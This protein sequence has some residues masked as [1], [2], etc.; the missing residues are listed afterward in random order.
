[1]L[2]RVEAADDGRAHSSGAGQREGVFGAVTYGPAQS[3]GSATLGGGSHGRT[4]DGKTLQ[5]R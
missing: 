4:V 1:M 2:P 5:R 3:G